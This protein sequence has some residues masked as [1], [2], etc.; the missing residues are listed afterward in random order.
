[1]SDKYREERK[2]LGKGK[3]N[4]GSKNPRTI[5]LYGENG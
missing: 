2:T 4:L 1:M 5:R 3:K